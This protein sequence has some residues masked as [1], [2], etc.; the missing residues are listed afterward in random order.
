MISSCLCLYHLTFCTALSPHC[1]LHPQSIS[2]Y[3]KTVTSPHR[4]VHRFHFFFS[5]RSTCFPHPATRCTFV[6]VV[7][8]WSGSSLCVGRKFQH[9]IKCIPLNVNVWWPECITH[10]YH[11]WILSLIIQSRSQILFWMFQINFLSALGFWD[12]VNF[13][14]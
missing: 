6:Q 13:A 11:L 8:F 14:S 7:K 5:H 10:L 1:L 3:S 12:V 2:F 9:V 4:W